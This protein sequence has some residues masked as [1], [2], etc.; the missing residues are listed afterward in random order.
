MKFINIK[1]V[2]Y[3]ISFI[4]IVLFWFG[5]VVARH[6]SFLLAMQYV[7]LIEGGVSED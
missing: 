4:G 3:A 7:A 6:C 2:G 5:L 1:A